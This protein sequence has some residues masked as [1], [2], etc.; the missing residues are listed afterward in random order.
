MIFPMIQPTAIDTAAELPVYR[1]V[2]WDFK[3]NVPV[4]KNGNPVIVERNDAIMTWAWKALST[5]RF[6]YEIYTWDYGNELGALIGKPY[7]EA[8]KQSEAVRYVSECLKI[9]PYIKDVQNITISFTDGVL[10]I[11]CDIVSV[12]G[13]I[14][15]GG[16]LN[17]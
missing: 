15:L 10:S 13:E 3:N 8:L 6:L 12:Y 14:K 5:E 16:D 1:E 4:Y 17:V 2:K 7:T 9:N 11:Q